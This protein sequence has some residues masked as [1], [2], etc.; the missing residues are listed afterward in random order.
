VS[1]EALGGTVKIINL[2]AGPGAGKSTTAAGVFNLMKIE[3]MS[4]ELVTEYAKDM[5]WEKRHNIL[6]DQLYMFAKQHR[7]ISRVQDAVDYVVTDS[8]LLL[9]LIYAGDEYP[10]SFKQLVL[11]YWTRYEHLNF[12][13]ERTK[14][15][16][17]VGRSQTEEEARAIDASVKSCL[18]T[19]GF[20][21]T[22][23][24]G[25][26]NAPRTILEGVRAAG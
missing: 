25:D 6:T 10:P 1:F 15:Y 4:V 11:D 3:G 12:F 16:V 5:T 20:S 22:V 2:F 14:E 17:A 19:N 7:R 26:N 21:F 9:T 24:P 18:E 13:I 8:P 23:I